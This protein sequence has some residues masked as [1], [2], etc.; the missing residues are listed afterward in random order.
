M[1]VMEVME[2]MELNEVYQNEMI[3]EEVKNILITINEN[4]V[5]FTEIFIVIIGVL[6]GLVVGYILIRV[7]FHG[8]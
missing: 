8:T 6:I 7:I 3:F 2:V 1:E 4:I 5:N